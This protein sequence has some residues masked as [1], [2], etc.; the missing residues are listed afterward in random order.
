MPPTPQD[1]ALGGGQRLSPMNRRP[2]L[3]S[4]SSD[5]QDVLVQA[6]RQDVAA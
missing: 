6:K 4:L 2:S 1:V 3:F 5:V